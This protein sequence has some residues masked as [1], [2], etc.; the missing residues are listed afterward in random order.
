LGLDSDRIYRF[1]RSGS[2]LHYRPLPGEN[3]AEVVHLRTNDSPLP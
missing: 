1:V 2:A 3:A